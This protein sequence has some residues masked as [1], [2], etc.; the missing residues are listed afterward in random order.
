ME[1]DRQPQDTT[2]LPWWADRMGSLRSLNLLAAGMTLLLIEGLVRGDCR[3][4]GEA[5]WVWGEPSRWSPV[6]RCGPPGCLRRVA[7]VG[8]EQEPVQAADRRHAALLPR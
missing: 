4:S 8:D 3:A 1:Q 2:P 6:P 5:R 7:G